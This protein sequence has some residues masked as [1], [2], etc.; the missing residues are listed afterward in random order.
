MQAQGGRDWEFLLV[1]RSTLRDLIA[2]LRRED[3]E[4]LSFDPQPDGSGGIL[5]PLAELEAQL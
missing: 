1:I 3:F 2:E 4:G 5:I